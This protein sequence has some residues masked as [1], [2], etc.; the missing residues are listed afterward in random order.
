MP[1]HFTTS[2][3]KNASCRKTKNAYHAK[4]FGTALAKTSAIDYKIYV[5]T[6]H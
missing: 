1:L 3:P 6:I 2:H 5:D 4:H